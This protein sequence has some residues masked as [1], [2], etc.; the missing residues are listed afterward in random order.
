MPKNC[1][2]DVVICVVIS[3]AGLA[4]RLAL[5]RRRLLVRFL[6]AEA[7]SP[8]ISNVAD[9][10]VIFARIGRVRVRPNVDTDFKA[11]HLWFTSLRALLS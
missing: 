4:R 8:C 1:G 10:S 2:V 7:A 6:R 5:R 11:R 9:G 3:T